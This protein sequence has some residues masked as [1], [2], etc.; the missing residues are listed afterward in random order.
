M[1]Y[2]LDGRLQAAYDD[3]VVLNSQS[4]TW[5]ESHAEAR[6]DKA[7]GGPVIVGLDGAPGRESGVPEGGIRGLAAAADLARDVH[8][9]LT[10]C[11]PQLDDMSGG[12]RVAARDNNTAYRKRTR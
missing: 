8:P 7:L 11:L 5:Y 12:Q 9:G 6:G 4:E 2:R 1:P 10:G 3:A